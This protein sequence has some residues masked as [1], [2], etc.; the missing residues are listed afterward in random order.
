M[1]EGVM[2]KIAA[3]IDFTEVTPRVVEFSAAEA[4]AHRAELFLLHVELDSAPTLYRKIDEA[5]R[6]RIATV[7][8]KEHSELLAKATE[9]REHL[10]ICVHPIL[11]EGSD[12][13]ATI[14]AE[15]RKLGAD[16]VVLG[17]HNHSKLHNYLFGSVGQGLIKDL[18][19]PLTLISI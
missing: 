8:S 14:V 1:K 11:I 5:E 18:D 12:V 10:S 6:K 13:E 15:V 2:M 9:L 17:N 19:C 7:L 4:A 16:H 3:L